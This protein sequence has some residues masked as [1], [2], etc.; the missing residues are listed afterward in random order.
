MLG[1]ISI[2]TDLVPVE[3]GY[4]RGQLLHSG[5]V[6]DPFGGEDKE[7]FCTYVLALDPKGW[8]PSWLVNM[9]RTTNMHQS[10]TH[11]KAKSESLQQQ[12][13]QRK[14]SS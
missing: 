9:F 13:F 12:A 3:D 11:L 5:W 1:A 7:T 14:S 4:V 10:F 6:L 8:A 2:E